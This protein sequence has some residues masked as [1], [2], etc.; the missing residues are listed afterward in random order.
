MSAPLLGAWWGASGTLLFARFSALVR[1][2]LGVLEGRTKGGLFYRGRGPLSVWFTAT[3]EG[4]P[5]P[6]QLADQE[7]IGLG[8]HVMMLSKL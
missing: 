7:R 4:Q 5:W 2:R 1:S 6:A 3:K 8:C